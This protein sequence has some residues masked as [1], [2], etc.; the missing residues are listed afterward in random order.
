MTEQEIIQGCKDHIPKYQKQLVVQYSSELLGVCYRYVGRRELAKDVLQE[1][2]LMIFRYLPNYQPTGSFRA[3]MKRIVA[4]TALQF[5]RSSPYKRE[6]MVLETV[7]EE[8]VAP[9]VYGQLG[10]EDLVELI[11]ELPEGFR[12]IFNLYAIEGYNHKEIGEL[13]NISEGTSRSQL[14]RARKLLQQRILD[15]K[16]R[17]FNNSQ[18]IGLGKKNAI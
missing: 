9:E 10:A 12:T 7:E 6:S 3:W 8:F 18:K 4:T 16:K 11:E 17:F 2:F 1:S 5:L 13:L 14:S 15:Q